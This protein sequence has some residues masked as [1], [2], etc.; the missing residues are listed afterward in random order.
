MFLRYYGLR[1]QPFGMTPDPR[2]LCSSVSHQEAFAS[3]V[4]AIETERGFAALIAKPGM[5]K[6]TLLFQLM[7]RLRGSAS[8]AFLFQSHEDSRGFLSSLIAD[9]GLDPNQQDLSSLQRQLDDV[10]VREAHAGRRFVLVIDEAQNLADSVLESVRML[11][12]FETPQAKLIHIVLSGQPELANKLMRPELAQL[13]QRVS[14]IAHLNSLTEPEVAHYIGHRLKVAGYHG[15]PLFTKEAL[16]IIANRSEGIPRNINNL[17]FHALS[18][19]FAKGQKRIDR[20]IMAE[21]LLDLNMRRLGER[22]LYDP[23]PETEPGGNQ[24]ASRSEAGRISPRESDS[25]SIDEVPLT[26]ATLPRS[27]KRGSGSPFLWAAG[28]L[29][30]ILCAG[31][32]WNSPFVKS[33]RAMIGQSVSGVIQESKQAADMPSPAAQSPAKPAP[34]PSAEADSQLNDLATERNSK[35]KFPG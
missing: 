9:L 13:R 33:R 18:L 26:P 23:N 12:N 24:T 5:G 20:S 3:L 7:E 14:V 34:Q 2:F 15:A 19:G 35:P 22:P 16:A 29:V 21:V 4:Y 1:E 17:C 31:F 27:Q 10:L 25:L 8:T 30:A 28:I 32:Y 11:S 6:T